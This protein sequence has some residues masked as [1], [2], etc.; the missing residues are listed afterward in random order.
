MKEI[1]TWI[2]CNEYV[3]ELLDAELII[4]PIQPSEEVQEYFLISLDD[5]MYLE[6]EGHRIQFNGKYVE[7]LDVDD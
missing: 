6:L 5:I 7:V 2:E 4:Q 3:E 1:K